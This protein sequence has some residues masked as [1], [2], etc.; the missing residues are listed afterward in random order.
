[1]TLHLTYRK[2]YMFV[3]NNQRLLALITIVII[4]KIEVIVREVG[5]CMEI[6]CFI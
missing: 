3:E 2:A 1:M 5:I 6:I 4:L